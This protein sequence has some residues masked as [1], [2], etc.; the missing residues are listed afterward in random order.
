MTVNGLKN[1][2]MS[3]SLLLG[4]INRST[5]TNKSSVIMISKACMLSKVIYDANLYG[6]P[7]QDITSLKYCI[8]KFVGDS[9]NGYIS[10]DQD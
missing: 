6:V 7:F 9:N 4:I 10:D 5:S 8:V 1:F 2:Y 3:Y